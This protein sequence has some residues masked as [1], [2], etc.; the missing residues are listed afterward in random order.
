MVARFAE[1]GLDFQFTCTK[2]GTRL[3]EPGHRGP[4]R[5]TRPSLPRCNIFGLVE[6]AE[7]FGFVGEALFDFFHGVEF[8]GFESGFDGGFVEGDAVGALGG[9]L[10]EGVV[11][12]HEFMGGES[13]FVSRAETCFAW[14]AIVVSAAFAGHAEASHESL[15]EDA[16]E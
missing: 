11:H 1:P 12:E 6:D 16:Q 8:H 13:A 15:G 14:V 5:Q 3:G 4:S 2:R 10:T 7:D 9:E